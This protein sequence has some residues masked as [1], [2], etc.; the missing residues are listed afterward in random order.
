MHSPRYNLNTNKYTPHTPN[1]IRTLIFLRIFPPT[2]QPDFGEHWFSAGG[3]CAPGDTWH[4]V[5]LWL[6][7]DRGEWQVAFGSCYTSYNT[8]GELCPQRTTTHTPTVQLKKSGAGLPQLSQFPLYRLPACPAC[9]E[10][11]RHEGAE[12]L[13]EGTWAASSPTATCDFQHQNTSR[14]SKPQNQLRMTE[15]NTHRLISLEP[16]LLV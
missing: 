3:A 2:I 13:I 16:A 1:L 15:I 9:S 11:T 6:T 12:A 14:M 4:L 5:S 7:G 8:R 10:N